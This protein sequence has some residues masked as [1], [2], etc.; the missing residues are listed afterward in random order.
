MIGNSVPLH[1]EVI[2]KNYIAKLIFR[3]LVL[4]V[5][6]YGY[7]YL[8]AMTTSGNDLLEC[9]AIAGLVTLGHVIPESI[10]TP[11]RPAI[12]C[13]VE[14]RGFLL[15]RFDHVRIY[16]VINKSQQDSMLEALEHGQMQSKHRELTVDFYEKENWTTWSD[17]GSGRRGGDRGPETP[18]RQVFIK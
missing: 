14:M 5:L 10:S 8:T 4:L 17:P 1:S 15:K 6:A 12:F 7:Y 11:G 2:K 13:D 18:I 9:K 16:G 3:L